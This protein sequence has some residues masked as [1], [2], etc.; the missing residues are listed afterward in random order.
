M[1]FLGALMSLLLGAAGWIAL[2]FFGR[3][4]RRF[5]DLRQ[6]CKRQLLLLWDTPEAV[7]AGEVL[8]GANDPLQEP[9]R[10]LNELGARLI[11]FD[12]SE[13]FAAW[14]VRWMRFNARKAGG[15]LMILANELGT[16]SESRKKNVR[17]VEEALKFN[18]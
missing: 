8:Y 12:A 1:S 13:P 7:S 4:V 5:F 2:E 17:F 18:R 11:S 15:G 6:E 10:V 14:F 16:L 9:K 3:P